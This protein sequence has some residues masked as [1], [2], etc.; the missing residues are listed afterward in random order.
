MEALESESPEKKTPAAGSLKAMFA[1]LVDED[2]EQTAAE[3][4][5]DPQINLYLSEPLTLR[6]GQSLAYW[7]ANKGR[8]PALA[9]AA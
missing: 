3:T 5:V 2:E 4:P 1:E 8:F 9:E 6:G 7:Q